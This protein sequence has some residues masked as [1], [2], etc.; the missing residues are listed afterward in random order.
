MVTGLGICRACGTAPT[1]LSCHA[2]ALPYQGLSETSPC[3]VLATVRRT[4]FTQA[5]CFAVRGKCAS[6]FRRVLR[7][8][9]DLILFYRADGSD[10]SAVGYLNKS[11]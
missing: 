6:R 1:D 9:K 8:L 5:L 4:A 7:I 10:A 2:L 11:V 3:G